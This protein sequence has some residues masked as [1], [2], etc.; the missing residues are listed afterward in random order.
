M[1]RCLTAIPQTDDALAIYLSSAPL[2]MRRYDDIDIYSAGL[3]GSELV[4]LFGIHGI[5]EGGELRDSLLQ[6]QIW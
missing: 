6:G 3:F 5:G 4:Q 2:S 1:G